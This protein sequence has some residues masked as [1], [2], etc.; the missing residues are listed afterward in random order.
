VRTP[1]THVLAL[2]GALPNPAVEDLLVRFSLPDATPAVLELFDVTGRQVMTK[3]VGLLGPGEHS[4]RL[5]QRGAL[6][7]GIYLLRLTRGQR[8]LT[9]RLTVMR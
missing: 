3:D 6:A 1:E 5:A 7:P 4:V 2:A 8:T 9:S